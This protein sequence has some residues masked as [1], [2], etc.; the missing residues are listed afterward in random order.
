MWDTSCTNSDEDLHVVKKKCEITV[1]GLLDYMSVNRLSANDGKTN[2]LVVPTKKNKAEPM[3][4]QIG[5][6]KIKDK[7]HEKLLGMWVS[8]N[9]TWS[10][11]LSK[12]EGQLNQRLFTLRRIEQVVPRSLLKNVADGIFVSKLRYGLA[13]FWPLRVSIQDPNP[14]E[15]QGIKVVFN[16]M[17]RLL[18]GTVKEDKV[19]IKKMLDRLGW[20][21]INQMAAETRLIEVWKALN[22]G[23]SLTGLFQRIQGNTRQSS[24]NRIK[25]MKNS[26]LRENSFMQPSAKLWNLAPV[27]VVKAQTEN[28]ARKAIRQF[29]KTLPL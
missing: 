2:I 15:M 26:S 14:T 4:F 29:V 28:Q 11:H 1:Q 12:L 19:S 25:L 10:H 13:I 21:S 27:S 17:L 7:Q 18:C 8:N 5:K 23:N 16:R 20:L 9:L 6:A 22:V 3:T 24:Q